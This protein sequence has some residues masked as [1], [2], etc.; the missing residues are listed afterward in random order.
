MDIVRSI[1]AALTSFPV[2]YIPGGGVKERQDGRRR[3]VHV[4]SGHTIDDARV[5]HRA[6]VTL[7]DAGYDV[8]LIGEGTSSG[9][10]VQQGVTIHALAPADSRSERIA[11]SYKVAELASRLKPDLFHVHE[12]ELLGPIIFLAKSRP[13]VWD[14]HES[15]LD[16]L[17]QR[18]WIPAGLRPAAKFVWDKIEKRLLKKCA[19]VI[20]V[21]ERIAARY[22]RLHPTVRVIA[23]YPNY[24]PDDAGD[25]QRIDNTCVFAG[26]LRSDRG[27]YQIISAL[28]ILRRKGSDIR[29]LLAGPES[30]DGFI[31]K[32]F[33][34]AAQEGV[35]DLISYAG[36]LSKPETS[37]FIRSGQIGFVTYL[38][39]GNNIAGLP[40]KLLECMAAGTPVVYSNFDSYAEVAGSSGGAG[41]AVDPKDPEAIARAIETIVSSPELICRFGENGRNAVRNI[42]NWEKESEKLIDLYRGIFHPR[43]AASAPHQPED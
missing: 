11:R 21:T 23:N 42:F 20:T 28:A 15:Y 22:R 8:H 24:I 38:P 26:G 18:E 19:A 17:D 30:E 40:T 9:Y 3:I 6:C 7:A 33:R 41:I 37:K 35:R 39:F 36:V 16:I 2:V 13:V 1:G 27:L 31:E 43:S 5:F 32:M 25:V 34:A 14:A 12:P 29:L 10:S 4:C